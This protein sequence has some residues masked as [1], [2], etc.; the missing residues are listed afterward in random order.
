MSFPFD[1]VKATAAQQTSLIRQLQRTTAWRYIEKILP[2]LPGTEILELKKGALEDTQLF[3][4]ALVSLE[5]TDLTEESLQQLLSPSAGVTMTT[6]VCSHIVDPN[7]LDETYF[8]KQFDLIVADFDELNGLSP[9]AVENFFNTLPS[10]LTPRGRFIGAFKTRFCLWSML[11]RACTLR[12]RK[13]FNRVQAEEKNQYG[14]EWKYQPSQITRFCKKGFKIRSI[15]PVGLFM[16]PLELNY[17][18]QNRPHWVIRLQ[19]LEKR[20]Q[21]FRHLAGYSDYF[22]IDMQVK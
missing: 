4:G 21:T 9:I 16:P 3:Q 13:L 18:F 20:F 5:A 1:H 6:Q 2:T 22:L 12:F 15:S 19:S 7:H 10:L 11:W 8:N 14:S 17:L